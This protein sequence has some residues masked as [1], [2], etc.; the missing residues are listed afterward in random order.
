MLQALYVIA[1]HFLKIC[2]LEAGPQDL[3]RSPPFLLFLIFIYA[4]IS[5]TI[6]ILYEVPLLTILGQTFVELGITLF[7][8]FSLLYV[9]GYYNRIIQTLTAIIGIDTLLHTIALIILIL[10]F[11]LKSI[12][13]DIGFTQIL[14]LLLFF[15]NLTVYAHILRHALS[16]EFIVGFIITFIYLIVTV[17]ILQSL[18]PTPEALTK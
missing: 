17:I 11:Y 5:T 13:L 3:P 4:L 9:T 12:N 15:W 14:A 6:L 7:L 18:F 16:S 1:Y 8:T 2:L 10:E